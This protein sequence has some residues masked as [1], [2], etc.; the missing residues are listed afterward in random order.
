LDELGL[1]RLVALF[2]SNSD[3]SFGHRPD[4]LIRTPE[5]R[6][7][8]LKKRIGGHHLSVDLDPPRA[9]CAR[10][11]RQYAATNDEG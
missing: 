10:R 6:P 4:P 8:E 11:A 9:Q 3:E 1:A 7:D 5:A 2:G